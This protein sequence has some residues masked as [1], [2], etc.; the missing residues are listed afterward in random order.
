MSDDASLGAARTAP[1]NRHLMIAAA[2]A[3]AMVLGLL[4]L[5]GGSEPGISSAPRATAETAAAAAEAG[6]PVASIGPDGAVREDPFTVEDDAVVPTRS[7]IATPGSQSRTSR[8][9]VAAAA[10]ATD[11][12]R[13]TSQAMLADR[14]SGL[15][16]L[17]DA[18][19]RAFLDRSRGSE[20]LYAS[21][22]P[23]S[24]VD[25]GGR[26]SRTGALIL[27]ETGI[28]HVDGWGQPAVMDVDC[29]VDLHD[30]KIVDFSVHTHR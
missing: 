9:D 29:H 13:C 20:P 12:R 3:A 6:S 30:L 24:A 16:K 14:F 21:D 25:L 4:G 8:E 17:A 15:G 2:A 11:W 18:C 19:R 28:Q 27:K 10:C 1:S 26:T 23:F 7:V 22:A 5:T